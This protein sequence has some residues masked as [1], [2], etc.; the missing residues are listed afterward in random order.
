MVKLSPMMWG[1][2]AA[3]LLVCAQL[4]LAEEGAREG[5]SAES[6]VNLHGIANWEVGQIEEGFSAKKGGRVDREF[7]NRASVWLWSDVTLSEHAKATLGVGGVYF[8]VFPRNLGDNPYTFTRR[9]G[10]GITEAS[11]DVNL[12]PNFGEGELARI[13]AGIFMYKSNPDTKNLGEYMFRTWTYPNVITTGGVDIID[14]T[15]TQLSG[16][17]LSSSQGGFKNDVLLTIQSDRPPIYGLSLTDMISYNIGG[18]LKVG[19]GYMWDNFYVPEKGGKEPKIKEANS[20]YTL[21]NGRKISYSKFIDEKNSGLVADSQVVDTSY[22]SFEGQKAVWMTS[23]DLGRILGFETEGTLP[24][25][26]GL[27]YE[28]VLM[29]IENRTTYFEKRNQRIAHMFG[30]NIPTFGA[31]DLLSFEVEKTSNPYRNS[32][33]GVLTEGSITPPV[34]NFSDPAQVNYTRDD[35][36]WSVLAKKKIYPKATL[37]LQVAND[38]LRTLSVFSEWEYLDMMQQP[39]HWYWAC[40]MQFSL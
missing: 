35:V 15:A 2:P 12:V 14:N 18:F 30:M 16:L 17:Q 34:S 40:K 37:M 32:T 7:L 11:L 23:L 25:T 8:F 29:G 28:G 20:I 22:N 21:S 36:K 5:K 38:H 31:L 26:F 6:P 33:A 39:D 1:M 9:S 3:L 19:V 13:K 4:P 24:S 10:M 27:Y